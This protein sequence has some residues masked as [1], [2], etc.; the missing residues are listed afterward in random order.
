MEPQDGG[1]QDNGCCCVQASHHLSCGKAVTQQQGEEK[2]NYRKKEMVKCVTP[3]I[4]YRATMSVPKTN[5]PPA[6]R[7]QLLWVHH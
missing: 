1:G 4:P 3:Q 6:K 2:K 7:V 5:M